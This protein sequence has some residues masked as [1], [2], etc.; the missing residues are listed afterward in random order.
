MS[1]SR[2][3]LIVIQALHGLKATYRMNVKVT[4]LHVLCT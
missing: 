2:E 3:R 1:I 4:R